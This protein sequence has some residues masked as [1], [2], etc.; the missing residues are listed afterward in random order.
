MEDCKYTK[1][2]LKTCEIIGIILGIIVGV[3]VGILFSAELIPI[4]V[5][6]IQIALVMSVVVLG[7]LLVALFSANAMKGYNSFYK[8]ICKFSKF[9]LTGSIGTLLSTTIAATL[10][11]TVISI[12]STIFVALSAFFFVLM[13]VSVVCLIS[14]IINETCRCKLD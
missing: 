9:V 3:A 4:T 14:C 11:V 13:I 1:S 10:G 2:G 6:F 8:C 5:N 7:I 12:I